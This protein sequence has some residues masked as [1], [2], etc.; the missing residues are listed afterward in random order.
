MARRRMSR[1][2]RSGPKRRLN[3]SGAWLSGRSVDLA[4]TGETVTSWV[5]F[6]RGI[7]NESGGTG[8]DQEITSV[9]ETLIRT[10]VGANVTL[11]LFGLLQAPV[12]VIACL[13]LIAWD[14]TT[15]SAFDL[16]GVVQPPGVVPDP[17]T[18]AAAEW[19][20]RIPFTFTRDNFSLGNIASEFIV[21][22]A[23]RKLPPRTGILACFSQLMPLDGDQDVATLDFTFDFRLLSKSG[24]FVGG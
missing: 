11:D 4:N 24:V 22:R 8:P 6:P 23:M 21:S 2:R 15:Q 9:D 14:A 3:W 19:L 20:M 12:N 5:I 18:D 1:G 10:I 7:R 17:V 13:G 16:D